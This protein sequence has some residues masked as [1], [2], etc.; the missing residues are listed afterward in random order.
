MEIMGCSAQKIFS[1][2]EEVACATTK[3]L[4]EKVFLARVAAEE[5]AKDC[6]R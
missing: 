3:E 2:H 4:E 1:L 6:E 5:Q